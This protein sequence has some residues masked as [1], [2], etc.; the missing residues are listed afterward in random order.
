[1]DE[2][3]IVVPVRRARKDRDVIVPDDEADVDD[4]RPGN[5]FLRGRVRLEGLTKVVIVMEVGLV[6]GD[7]VVG[8]R[9]GGGGRDV[10]VLERAI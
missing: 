2:R 1:M 9:P 7:G 3:Q 8:V 4:V 5:E 10:L 6:F